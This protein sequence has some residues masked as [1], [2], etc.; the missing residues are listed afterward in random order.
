MPKIPI[1]QGQQILNAGSPVPIAGTSEAR[2]P[3]EQVS[4]FGK[5]LMDFALAERSAEENKSKSMLNLAMS[6]LKREAT[7]NAIVAEGT[8]DE[9]PGRAGENSF[10]RFVKPLDDFAEDLAKNINNPNHKREFTAHARDYV[11]ALGDDVRKIQ[12]KKSLAITNSNNDMAVATRA[13][14]AVDNPQMRDQV[15]IEGMKVYDDTADI[16]SPEILQ[17]KK[18]ELAPM[19]DRGIIEG[20]KSRGDF[21]S[22]RAHAKKHAASFSVEGIDKVNDSIDKAEHAY[23][24]QER[25][26]KR[27]KD[28]EQDRFMKE[29]RLVNDA[30][31]G[32]RFF[33]ANVPPVER[34]MLIKDSERL[35]F[36]GLMSKSVL[37]AM[38][39]DWKTGSKDIS[40][41]TQ[42][43][44]YAKALK[45]QSFADSE[46]QVQAALSRD[47][48]ESGFMAS[49][50][51][52]ALLG[53]LRALEKNPEKKQLEQDG[54]GIVRAAWKS[55]ILDDPTIGPEYRT[56]MENAV[57]Y[58]HQL[59]AK[60]IPPLAAANESRER[61]HKA[62]LIG[63]GKGVPVDV[64]S[65]KDAIQKELAS[66]AP[67]F[68]RAEVDGNR[69]EMKRLK[70]RMIILTQQLNVLM[71]NEQSQKAIKAPVQEQKKSGGITDALKTW[72]GGGAAQ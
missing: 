47:G 59:T 49:K 46:K 9:A 53:R 38:K 60:G 1:Q 57:Y 7:R 33:A 44:I 26:D 52:Y 31:Y 16:Y 29:T 12:Y 71:E 21:E 69:E 30:A 13:Q 11:S 27:F 28:Y 40:A 48:H 3:G 6:S 35:A 5:G 24:S 39:N 45:G 17:Q 34:E 32:T 8:K 51:G 64:A 58:Y 20:M 55:S 68:K 63:I 56:Q 66:F 22:A 14:M 72:F 15:I 36:Q 67:A 19:I 42:V 41:K 2:I 4:A 25:A 50:D 54:E 62:H 10:D 37:S 61:Y 43:D 70:S 23:L 65:D 18:A